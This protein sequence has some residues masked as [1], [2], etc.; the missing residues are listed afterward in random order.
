[1]ARKRD[2]NRG[3]QRCAPI[4]WA[5]WRGRAWDVVKLLVAL[6]GWLRR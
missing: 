1:M 5:A 2:R 4:N 3:R 6:L